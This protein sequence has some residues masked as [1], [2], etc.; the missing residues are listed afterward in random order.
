MT[1]QEK[2][3]QAVADYIRTDGKST[4]VNPSAFQRGAKWGWNAALDQI[5]EDIDKTSLPLKTKESVQ[6]LAEIMKIR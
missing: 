4:I 1:T 2:I 6:Q 5:I 3:K